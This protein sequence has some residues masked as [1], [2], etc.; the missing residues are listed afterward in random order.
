MSQRRE[1]A[2]ILDE[3][4]ISRAITRVAHEIAER[5]KGVQ[6]IVLVGLRSRIRGLGG[7]LGICL[8]GSDSCHQGH[9]VGQFLRLRRIGR[10]LCCRRDICLG[11]RFR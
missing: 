2:Q 9:D 8:P 10:D 1:K 3:T 5:N 4:G 6:D 11:L 7:R